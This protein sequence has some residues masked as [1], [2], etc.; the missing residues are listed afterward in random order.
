MYK[1]NKLILILIFS[2]STI[3]LSQIT[4]LKGWNKA[5]WGI[6][7]TEIKSIFKEQADSIKVMHFGDTYSDIYLPDFKIGDYN[8]NVYFQFSKKSKKLVSVLIKPIISDS[9][10]L[11]K[12]T[13][14]QL[15]EFELKN[16]F[17]YL[18]QKLIYKYGKPTL[19]KDT[20]DNKTG[21]YAKIRNWEFFSSVI[22]FGLRDDRLFGYSTYILYLHYK[23]KEENVD[24]KL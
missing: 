9:T 12:N 17:D 19:S 23:M 14:S 18:E 7:K 20:N 21:S 10:K 13:K 1:I 4:D 24:D 2:L 16:I 6:D 15:S 11:K 5:H 3:L 8:F 22:E